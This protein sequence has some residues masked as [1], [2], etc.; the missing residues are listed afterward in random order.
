MLKAQ[1]V[2]LMQP[3]SQDVNSSSKQRK[4]AYIYYI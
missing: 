2:V 3:F 4:A 1:I